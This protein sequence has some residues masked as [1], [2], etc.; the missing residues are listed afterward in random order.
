MKNLYNLSRDHMNIIKAYLN[1]A[2]K[3]PDEAMAEAYDFVRQISDNYYV[4]SKMDL[5][6]NEIYHALLHLELKSYGSKNMVQFSRKMDTTKLPS[7]DNPLDYIIW[8]TRRY[9][10]GDGAEDIEDLYNWKFQYRCV[11][12]S[13]Y[14]NMCCRHY[15]DNIKSTM[16][17]IYTGYNA[18]VYIDFDIAKHCFN[19]IEYGSKRYLVD[20]TY[21]QFFNNNLNHVERM[22]IP[23][24]EGP[25]VGY[26]M[27]L[28]EKRRNIAYK[29][30][31]DG[32]IELDDDVF[33]IYLD[34]FTLA[35]RN[36]LYYENG[37]KDFCVPYSIDDYNKFLSGKDSQ[38]KH[39]KVKCLGIQ[40]QPLNNPNFDFKSISL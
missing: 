25:S 20:V 22:G 30:L 15:F 31:T 1:K 39:E 7:K 35:F 27:S 23:R 4:D 34:A 9:L 12:A 21:A 37:D 10:M 33:K 36:G 8:N 24:F 40:Y 19:I 14:V 16:K 3:Y 18:S 5:N 2:K 11:D 26:Y 28:T 17:T 6:Y 32:Y 38:V 29:L 13:E